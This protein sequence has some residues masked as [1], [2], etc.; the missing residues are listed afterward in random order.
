MLDP[1]KVSISPGVADAGGLDERGI[2]AT[3]VTAYLHGRG[4]EVEKTTDSRSY[5]CSSIGITKRQ[6]GGLL[7]A[8]LDFKRDYEANAPIARVL[9]HLASLESSECLRRARL[10]RSCRRDVLAAAQLSRQTL[11]RGGV[12]DGCR[13]ARDDAEH[14]VSA[15]CADEIEHVPLDALADHVEATSVVAYPPGIPMLVPDEDTSVRP[16]DRISAT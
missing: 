2:P 3:L 8:L 7:N 11:A 5:S 16:M 15:S 6:V 9:P 4:V 10:E 1:I 13:R 14:R 12:L